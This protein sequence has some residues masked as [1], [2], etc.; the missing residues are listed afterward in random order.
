MNRTCVPRPS[1]ARPSPESSVTFRHKVLT[2]GRSVT[3]CHICEHKI[4]QAIPNVT[5]IS[6]VLRCGTPWLSLPTKMTNEPVQLPL[7]HAL[8]Q[9]DFLGQFTIG[10]VLLL[11]LLDIK[12]GK[13]SIFLPVVIFLIKRR[14]KASNNPTGRPHTPRE[15]K[16]RGQWRPRRQQNHNKNDHRA[17]TNAPLCL[18]H[19]KLPAS[20]HTTHQCCCPPTFFGQDPPDHHTPPTRKRPSAYIFVDNVN[21]HGLAGASVSAA[22]AQSPKGWP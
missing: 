1:S 16:N 9:R 21:W 13:A 17:K 11:W 22:D 7:T 5:L 6:L 8:G 2:K 4:S 3:R 14:S 10:F 19:T 15:G 18:R 12:N 20:T